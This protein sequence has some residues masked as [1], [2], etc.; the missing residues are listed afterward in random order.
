MNTRKDK[1]SQGD[2]LAGKK[3]SGLRSFFDIPP[4]AIAGMLHIELSGNTEAVVDGCVGVLEYDETTVRLAGKKMSVK[5]TGRNLHL[6]ILTHDS[7]IL[8]G[9]ILGVEYIV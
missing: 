7:A 2:K 1:I 8:E 5:F 3:N 9:F 6:K 4:S